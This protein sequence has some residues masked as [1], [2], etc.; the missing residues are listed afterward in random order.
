MKAF[1]LKWLGV[2]PAPTS[3]TYSPK[4]DVISGYF[5]DTEQVARWIRVGNVVYVSGVITGTMTAGGYIASLTL[6]VSTTLVEYALSGVGT[7]EGAVVRFDTN[8]GLYT[9][10]AMVTCTFP[11]SAAATM[12]YSFSY[13][14]L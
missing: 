14:V 13:E 11:S 12:T 8:V 5:A 3:G 10:K 6:P 1:I 4:L 2:P 9:D 7:I